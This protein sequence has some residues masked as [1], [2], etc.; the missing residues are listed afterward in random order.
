MLMKY[1]HVFC[2]IPVIEW[3]PVD[4]KVGWKTKAHFTSDTYC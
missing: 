2:P 4:F 1:F 3:I